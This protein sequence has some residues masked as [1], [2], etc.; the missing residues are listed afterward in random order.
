MT[1]REFDL[2]DGATMRPYSMDDLEMLW[3]A[4]VPE[5]A[6]IG[7]WLRWADLLGSIGYWLVSAFEGRG[8]ITRACRAIVSH[9]FVEHE[10]H[11]VTIASAVT[12]T[13]SRAVPERLGFVLDGVARE[14]TRTYEGFS[15]LAIYGILDREW[16][17]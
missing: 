9:A 4:V 8:L 6:R 15:D 12:N 3:S 5:R 13:R 1:R 14:A 10:A 2:T 16:T 11:R 7:R 17:P